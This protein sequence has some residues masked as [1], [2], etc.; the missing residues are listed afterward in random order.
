V[1]SIFLFEWRKSNCSG[2]T[3]EIHQDGFSDIVHGMG[4]DDH[5]K[6]KTPS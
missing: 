1:L 6:A 2:T 5:I 3:D 4:G